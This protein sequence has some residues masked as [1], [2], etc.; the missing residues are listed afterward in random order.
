MSHTLQDAIPD[1]IINRPDRH[2]PMRRLAFR[3]ITV[4]FWSLYFY[5]WLPAITLGAWWLAA[6]M[7]IHEFGGAPGE[8]FDL[9][10]LGTLGAAASIAFVLMIGWAEYNRL[11]FQH[12][13]RRSSE[14]PVEPEATAAAFDVRSSV[15]AQLRVARHATLVLDG[16]AIVV[17][18]HAGRPS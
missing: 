5:L 13:V 12:H 7:G 4:G 8:S 6:R 2:A 3:A 10:L 9:R 17:D 18:V 14:P 11:R 15:A 16:R 1:L